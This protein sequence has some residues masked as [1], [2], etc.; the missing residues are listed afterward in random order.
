MYRDL[1]HHLRLE[2]SKTGT[3]M[4]GFNAEAIN[5]ASVREFIGEYSKRMRK[6]WE[7]PEDINFEK[8]VEKIEKL[9]KDSFMEAEIDVNIEGETLPDVLS[10]FE[11][12]TGSPDAKVKLTKKHKQIISEL[13]NN[14]KF[15]NNK[16]G[17]ELNDES[18]ELEIMHTT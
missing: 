7:K 9:E 5:G 12:L 16:M 18:I 8:D 4:L 10:G 2:S 11:G 3:S 6:S 17:V 14:L 1:L 15:Y 13:V